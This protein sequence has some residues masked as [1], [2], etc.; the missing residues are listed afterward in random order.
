MTRLINQVFGMNLIGQFILDKNNLG[1]KS[2]ISIDY[3]ISFDFCRF[4]LFCSPVN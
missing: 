4:K 2:I 3:R 1:G